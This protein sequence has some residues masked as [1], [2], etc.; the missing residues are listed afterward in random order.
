V[1]SNLGAEFV[2]ST[3]ANFI[4]QAA[5][6]PS[7]IL[8]I[9]RVLNTPT[10]ESYTIPYDTD[11]AE[12]VLIGQNAQDTVEDVDTDEKELNSYCYTSKMVKVP[13]EWLRD[14]KFPVESFV[15]QTLG[16]R[17]ARGR[18]RAFATADGSNKPQ[19]YVN[20]TDGVTVGASADVGWQEMKDLLFSVPL[21]YRQSPSFAFRISDALASSLMGQEDNNGK[22]IWINSTQDG[23]PDRLL[24]KP[25]YIDPYLS[26]LSTDENVVAVA[27]DWNEFLVRQVGA[28]E[29]WSEKIIDYRQVAIVAFEF[30]E[31]KILATTAFRRMSVE[32]SSS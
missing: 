27:G 29:I 3:L 5:E 1:T 16:R 14:S 22:P 26:D 18:A 24:G 4:H 17:L 31:S 10:G 30:I 20:V 9:C 15:G 8:N 25:V 19:G 12:S 21:A 32:T 13:V 7:N 28:I 11:S 2:P 6:Y 23:Q